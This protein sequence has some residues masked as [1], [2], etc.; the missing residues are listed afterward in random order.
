[1]FITQLQLRMALFYILDILTVIEEQRVSDS[2]ITLLLLL[3]T[4]LNGP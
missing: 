1:M 2:K 3:Q 4:S